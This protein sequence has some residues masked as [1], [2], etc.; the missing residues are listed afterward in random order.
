MLGLCAWVGVLQRASG[1]GYSKARGMPAIGGEEGGG[2]RCYSGALQV[3]FRDSHCV[4]RNVTVPH[5][6]RAVT[7]P[8]YLSPRH[9]VIYFPIMLCRSGGHEERAQVRH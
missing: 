2:M 5:A 4:S 8:V 3:R 7:T 9:F 1:T 6:V